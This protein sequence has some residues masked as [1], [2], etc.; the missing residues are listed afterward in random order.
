MWKADKIFH[1]F[2]LI[3]SWIPSSKW[4][5]NLRQNYCI[6]CVMPATLL[7]KRLW[8]RRFLVN[9]CV[10]SRGCFCTVMFMEIVT[11]IKAVTVDFKDSLVIYGLAI[12]RNSLPE[13][14]YKKV[15]FNKVASWDL[16][17]ETLVQVFSCEFCEIFKST[18]E[19]L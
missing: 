15:F 9:S 19:L 16:R 5:D 17:F 14:F 7:K 3:H 8:H 6:I 4:Y 1:K 12:V 2:Y 13:V 10:F 18:C 11:I